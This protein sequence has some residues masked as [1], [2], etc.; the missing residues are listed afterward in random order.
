MKD[1]DDWIEKQNKNTQILQLICFYLDYIYFTVAAL[2]QISFMIK[3]TFI[4]LLD[5]FIYLYIN[6]KQY[7]QCQMAAEWIFYG[8]QTKANKGI[9]F[10]CLYMKGC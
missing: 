7:S 6:I 1:G 3:N 9:H 10:K 4:F 5:Y 8:G 2:G